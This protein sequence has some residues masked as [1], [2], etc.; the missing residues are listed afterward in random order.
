MELY[1]LI[2]EPTIRFIIASRKPHA[3]SVGMNTKSDYILSRDNSKILE[4]FYAFVNL[5]N[6]IQCHAVLPSQT[7]YGPNRGFLALGSL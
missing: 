2:L 6:N 4:V 7:R 1:F 3:L 5:T